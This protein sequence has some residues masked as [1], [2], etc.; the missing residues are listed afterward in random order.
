MSRRHAQSS[1]VRIG[2]LRSHTADILDIAE[3]AARDLGNGTPR[4]G[5]RR[6]P[7]APT[8]QQLSLQLLLQ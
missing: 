8:D 1:L 4:L 2:M 7:V 6:N 5:K 3:D